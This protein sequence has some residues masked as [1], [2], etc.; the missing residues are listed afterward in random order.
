MKWT[1]LILAALALIVLIGLLNTPV[2]N[3]GPD[4]GAPKSDAD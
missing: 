2:G 3:D 1:L 4:P